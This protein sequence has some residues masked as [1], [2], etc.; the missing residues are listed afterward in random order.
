MSSRSEHRSA[1]DVEVVGQWLEAL[2][3][4]SAEDETGSLPEI[5]SDGTV[6]CRLANRIK[7][8]SITDLD[9]TRTRQ[10][11]QKNIVNFLG[12]CR[13][14]ELSSS[15]ELED[16]ASEHGD[17]GQVLT[18]LTELFSK[19]AL[20]GMGK[21]FTRHLSHKKSSSSSST[22]QGGLS[23][24][25]IEEEVVEETDSSDDHIV[26]AVYAYYG[27]ER[28]ELSFKVGDLIAVTKVIDGGWWE[29]TCS[30]KSGWF[31]GNHVQELSAEEAATCKQ[32]LAADKD[33][34]VQVYHNLVVQNIMDSE[35]TYVQE[36]KT[37]LATYLNPL[38]AANI[39][40]DE[41]VSTLMGNIAEIFSFQERFLQAIEHCT[42][43]R[44]LKQMLGHIFL[45]HADELERLYCT[46]V[47]NHPRAVAVLTDYSDELSAFMEGN[48]ATA[49]GM[50]TLTVNLSKPLRRLEKYPT[51]MMELGRQMQDSHPDKENVTTANE[52]YNKI[53][54]STQHLR[55]E[56]EVEW[57]MVSNPVDGWP[58]K[59][60]LE[61]GECVCMVQ[62]NH[63][64]SEGE[65]TD[66]F[67]LVFSGVLVVLC[68]GQSL[69]GY[70]LKANYPLSSISVR[71]G[72]SSPDWKN[73]LELQLSQGGVVRASLPSEE[74][75]VKFLQATAACSGSQP[76][77][78][79]PTR[80][81][82]GSHGSALIPSKGSRSSMAAGGSSSSYQKSVSRVRHTKDTPISRALHWGLKSLRP[83]TPLT[84]TQLVALKEQDKSPKQLRRFIYSGT[85]KRRQS[86]AI[87]DLDS[88]D[89]RRM[90]VNDAQLLR[91]IEGY[92]GMGR[93]DL[94]GGPD[95]LVVP[96]VTTLKRTESDSKPRSS[97]LAKFVSG[98]SF[99]G[100]ERETKQHKNLKNTVSTPL[101]SS[102]PS[103]SP[104]L[105][106]SI[107]GVTE[108]LIHGLQHLETAVDSLSQEAYR[109]DFK[110]ERERQMRTAIDIKLDMI[111]SSLRHK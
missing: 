110:L 92:C 83:N 30:G 77:S 48:G 61:L 60:L 97:F 3:L 26:R 43:L 49:P 31:P 51:E 71:R 29:G 105:Q 82:L 33:D 106:E 42:G 13:S 37:V 88:K 108:S 32:E 93:T 76:S 38:R 36:L 84:S 95:T 17:F 103:S 5:L 107:S 12:V 23:S 2:A 11:T 63:L 16:L 64:S 109:I 111:L 96:V 9:Y 47:S 6:L 24:R 85:K 73:A 78:N 72:Q 87:L 50:L 91:V 59:N 89:S 35:R 90:G 41:Q 46:Y 67:Y 102:N 56:K 74:L 99:D 18:T 39:L 28:D 57:E 8:G 81:R 65:I 55:R 21:E 68:V 7:P 104:R 94:P 53:M 75:L 45:S 19:A 80:S 100:G 101:I 54:T 62:V 58:G 40:R 1:D 98:A 70:E 52:R 44:V 15:F 14:L 27:S 86:K 34:S 25:K 22:I 69:N 20:F 10:G 4:I 66:R 79:L